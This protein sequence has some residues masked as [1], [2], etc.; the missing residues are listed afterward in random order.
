MLL[1]PAFLTL[2][3]A[4]ISPAQ[5]GGELEE[6]LRSQAAAAAG[7]SIE[8]IYQRALASREAEDLG[9]EG[10]LDQLLERLL[11]AGGLATASRLFLAAARLQGPDP[12]PAVLAGALEP[13]LRDPDPGVVRSA[14]GLLAN[15]LFRGLGKERRTELGKALLAGARD[16]G[17]DPEERMDLAR[18][19]AKVGMGAE[20]RQAREEMRAFLDSADANL[21]SLGALALAGTG[22]ELEGRL[23]TELERLSRLPTADGQLA[24]AFLKQEE[25]KELH[26]RRYKDL[27]DEVEGG[28]L[29][30]NLKRFDAVLQM[31]MNYHLEGEHVTEDE[32]TEAAMAGM[33]R[34]MDEHSTYFAPEEY[35]KFLLDLEAEYGGIGAYV[36]IDNADKLFTISRPIYSGPAYRAGLQT[37]DKVVRIDDWPTLGEPVDDVIKRLKGEPG[38]TVKLYVWRRGMDPDLVD[39]P[40]E[41]MA[42]VLQREDIH[43]PAVAHQMLPGGIGL[44]EVSTFSRD[45]AQELK[46]AILEL[47]AQGLRGLVLD[48]RRNS[49]GLLTEARNV[50]DLFLPPGKKVVETQ[51]TLGRPEVLR[52]TGEPILPEDAPL[53]VLTSRFTASASEIV[54]GAL[55]DWERATI[56]GETSFG[57]GSVQQL[58]PVQGIEED[59]WEDENQNGRFD[60]WEKILVDHNGNGTVDYSP[61]VKMTIA[62]YVLPTGRSIHRELAA[63]GTVLSEGGI[64]PD[65]KVAFPLIESWR[66]VERRRVQDTKKIQAY[67]DAH[68]S[69]EF[70]LFRRLAVCDEKDERQYPE[71]DRLMLDLETTLPRD[72]VRMLVRAE[73]R[74]RIQDDR[75]AE[76]PIG[77]FQED[78]QVQQAIAFLLKSFDESPEAYGAY[79]KTFLDPEQV[80]EGRVTAL[81]PG[82]GRE[83]AEAL[84]L[85]MR[86]GGHAVT[87]EQLDQLLQTLG[88]TDGDD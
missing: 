65:L 86:D 80:S 52:T 55:Q 56:L 23:R 24:A 82:R 77:D 27:R 2:S 40:S 71:F 22:I 30:E 6:L 25:I 36:G 18:A 85:E 26:E 28:D 57:K 69:G 88:Y 11:G 12:D 50:S 5:G 44:V 41:D 29:P 21:R 31:V 61:R 51:G 15:E 33:L 39:R 66:V 46:R 19:C 84:I 3:L 53:V 72:D 32:L 81:A 13:L 14:A 4:S 68:F 47:K 38:T 9:A 62:K 60:T 74:R 35:A 70:D 83:Q 63:D 73:V 43:I 1:T 10:E 58:L 17:R 75:G 54:A 59:Q 76:F 45:V 7:L 87:A 64:E 79:G 37:D 78:Y 67:V 34:F 8:E 16:A 49:G 48:L 20:M 42:V